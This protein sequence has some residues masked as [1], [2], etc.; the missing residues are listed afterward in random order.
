MCKEK[1]LVHAPTTKRVEYHVS[2][3]DGRDGIFDQFNVC[4]ALV[5]AHP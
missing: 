3:V 2:C 5:D 4:V 1:T